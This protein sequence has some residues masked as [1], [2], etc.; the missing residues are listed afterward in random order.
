[1]KN[2]IKLTI[3]I[4]AILLATISASTEPSSRNEKYSSEILALST[5]E[6]R[7]LFGHQDDLC[8]GHAWYLERGRSDVKDVCGDYPAVAGFDLGGIEFGDSLNIDKVPFEYIRLVA[9]DHIARGGI[10]TFS[11]H[12]DNP[13]TGGNSWD[14]SNDQAVA[15]ILPGGE[16]HSEF[17]VWLTRLGDF[18]ASINGGN[19]IIFRPWHENLGNWF[20]WGANLC[21]E[22]EFRTLWKTTYDYLTGER[23]LNLLWAYSPNA[24][25]TE[26]EYMSRYPGDEMTDLLGLDAY[27]AYNYVEPDVFTKL[28]QNN[29][30]Y[31]RKIAASR[32][33]IFALTETGFES[34]PDPKW[35]TEVL[36]KVL[37]ASGVAYVLCWRN[38][39]ERQEHY[40]VPF[41][42]SASEENFI[43]FYNS[44]KSLFL[45]DIRK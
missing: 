28:L 5:S 39:Y 11:W 6:G 23:G 8:Y 29:L 18:L 41:K 14:I 30:G 38:A 26:M 13:V 45:N 32:N 24:G 42:G 1:V 7:Y 4:T 43:E 37:D 22:Q 35:W 40:Y 10:V 17:M 21:T 12:V 3:S 9:S 2:S 16:K 31:I 36:G 20:W 19:G 25:I 27:Q 34:I 33:K 44:K 15:S